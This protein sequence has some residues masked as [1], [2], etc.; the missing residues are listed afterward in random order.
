ML[1]YKTYWIEYVQ[2]TIATVE[3]VVKVKS[4]NGVSS[5]Y[6]LITDIFIGIEI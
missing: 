6:Y 2:G 4:L 3:L 1:K 5:F